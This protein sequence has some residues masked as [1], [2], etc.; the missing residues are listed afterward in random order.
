VNSARFNAPRFNR[1]RFNQG[2]SATPPPADYLPTLSGEIDPDALDW[3]FTLVE[4]IGTPDA[5]P[6]IDPAYTLIEDR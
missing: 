6:D 2:R 3:R 1:A 4:T 5:G